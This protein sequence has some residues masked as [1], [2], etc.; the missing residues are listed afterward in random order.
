MINIRI[1]G[2]T[3]SC[4][5]NEKLLTVARRNNI[6]IPTLCHSDAFPG[7]GCCRLCVVEV[8]ENNRTKVV[9]SCMYPVRHEIDVVTD[10][11]K[12]QNH[13]KMIIAMMRSRAP[14]SEIIAKLSKKYGADDLILS[15]PVG[16]KCILCGLC[17]RACDAVGAGSVVTRAL[18]K[19]LAGMGCAYP[20]LGAGAISMIGRGVTKKVSTPYKEP[21]DVCIGCCACAN[22]CPTG[23][24]EVI[25]TDTTRTIWN[26]SFKLVVCKECGCVLGTDKEV[27]YASQRVGQEP[28]FLCPDCRNK[29]AM[30]DTAKSV[31]QNNKSNS[32]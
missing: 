15:K 1:N 2:I 20:V 9:V 12:I 7:Q 26:K 28:I 11:P 21:S 5:K 22:V 31:S 6:F 19:R 29:Q 3:C 17:V 14:N 30:M 18:L 25:N 8:T 10:S 24:I 32:K 16:D 4:N 27:R 23:A 13:R